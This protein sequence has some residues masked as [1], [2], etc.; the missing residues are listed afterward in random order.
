MLAKD[1]PLIIPSY[2]KSIMQVYRDAAIAI[3]EHRNDLRLLSF[4]LFSRRRYEPTNPDWDACTASD[5]Y[6]PSWVP[7]WRLRPWGLG[8]TTFDLGDTVHSPH[9]KFDASGS[10]KAHVNFSSDL[11]IMHCSGIVVGTINKVYGITD[12]MEYVKAHDQAPDE[13]W[14]INRLTRPGDTE[15]YVA[16]GTWAT[17]WIETCKVLD[18]EW[19]QGDANR[20]LFQPTLIRGET[21]VRGETYENG[22]D[23]SD[24]DLQNT[25]TYG[26]EPP[27]NW[28]AIAAIIK[29]TRVLKTQG[30][31]QWAERRWH[32][33]CLDSGHVGFGGHAVREGDISCVLRGGDYPFILRERKDG[34]YH[35]VSDSYIHGIMHGEYAMMRMGDGQEWEELGII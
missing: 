19:F 16:E 13:W 11:K 20:D 8:V 27:S 28:E 30:K 15:D 17:A 1:K 6:W 23:Y 3:I 32:P 31:D 18:K 35:L 5:T 24:I 10:T 4:P 9:L 21:M 12:S 7:D 2:R 26:S 25:W 33:I 29:P 34:L 22:P 14:Q